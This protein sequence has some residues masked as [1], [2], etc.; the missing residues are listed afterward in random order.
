MKKLSISLGF[1]IHNVSPNLLKY[2][3]E[4]EEHLKDVFALGGAKIIDSKSNVE[5]LDAPRQKSLLQIALP[6]P[7]SQYTSYPLKINGV[8]RVVLVHKDNCLKGVDYP[9]IEG[10][11]EIVQYNLPL[12]KNQ[13]RI[14]QIL[15][16][17]RHVFINIPHS[18]KNRFIVMLEGKEHAASS[19][20]SVEQFIDDQQWDGEIQL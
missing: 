4:L 19:L 12:Y 3:F 1:E 16:Y 13:D 8:E 9:T 14:H 20:K 11:T 7:Y 15:F 2:A 18:R 6:S 10:I 5:I 17:H